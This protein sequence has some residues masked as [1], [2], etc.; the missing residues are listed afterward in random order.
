MKTVALILADPDTGRLGHS[1]P[2]DEVVG[3]RTVLGATAQRVSR[4]PGIDAVAVLLPAATRAL[5]PRAHDELDTIDATAIRVDAFD[6]PD[7]ASLRRARRAWTQ[8]GWRGGLGGATVWDELLPA[9]VVA[10]AAARLDADAVLLVGGDWPLVDPALCGELLAVHRAT[11]DAMK[12]AF[13]QAPPGLT[14]VVVARELLDDMARNDADFADLLAYSP[15]RP[16]VDPIGLDFCVG[17]P[18]S[19]RDTARRFVY[20]T[21]AG[22]RRIE[23]VVEAL[24]DEAD[25]ADALRVTEAC[26]AW[27]QDEPEASR[28]AELPPQVALELTPRRVVN[29]PITPQHHVD[30]DRGAASWEMIEKLAPQLKGRVVTLG[31]LGEP[32]LH[33]RWHDAV[34][35]IKQAGV[36]AVALETDLLLPEP[37]D[38][39]ALAASVLDSGVDAVFVRLNAE[40]AETYRDEMGVDRFAEVMDVIQALFRR[41]GVPLGRHATPAV[42]PMLTKTQLTTPELETFFERWWQL[43]RHAVVQRYPTGG[44]G[45]F[46]LSPDRNPVP[47]DGPWREP[48][49]HQRKQRLTVWSDGEVSL[50]HQDWHARASLGNV[51]DASL[52]ELWQGLP[53]IE[54]DADWSPDASP[55][56]RR[57]FD[58][59]SLHAASTRLVTA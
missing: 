56:C 10:A 40:S 3:A 41:R 48:D 4:V 7:A 36:L 15:K 2:I 38:A 14:G 55:M 1:R 42:V 22:R 21:S 24:G 53:R 47:M 57:C 52:I 5:S 6:A 50:C 51:N 25:T 39:E 16:A 23:A 35:A 20:D 9:S 19:V 31:G 30:I 59:A 18:A 17:I 8:D 54:L 45:R 49:P 32:L 11:P 46:A 58:F 26:R 12:L 29:G 34:A 44:K 37:A 43:A 13:C 27:E 33:E 28:F